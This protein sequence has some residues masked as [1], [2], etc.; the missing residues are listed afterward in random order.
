[1]VHNSLRVG[2]AAGVYP[3]RLTIEAV[4]TSMEIHLMR[5]VSL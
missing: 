1:M 3:Y 2:E 5:I 4:C